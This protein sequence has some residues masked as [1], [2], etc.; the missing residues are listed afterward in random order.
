[1]DGSLSPPPYVIIRRKTRIKVN[2]Y[3]IEAPKL[4]VDT[5]LNTRDALCLDLFRAIKRLPERQPEAQ[6]IAAAPAIQH[7]FL[8][9]KLGPYVGRLYIAHRAA[10]R[11]DMLLPV[12]RA[13]K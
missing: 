7:P 6:G 4:L 11:R 9:R 8:K 13:E 5:I 1:M 2:A 3:E 10:V 12:I